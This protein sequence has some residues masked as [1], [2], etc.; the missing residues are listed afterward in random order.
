MSYLEMFGRWL[1]D[2][3]HQLIPTVNAIA[4]MIIAVRIYEWGKGK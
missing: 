2:C 1:I 4:Y 3:G